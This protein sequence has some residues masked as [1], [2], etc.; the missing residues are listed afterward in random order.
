MTLTD[1]AITAFIQANL[2]LIETPAVP[3][4]RLHQ[5]MP[6]SGLHRLAAQDAAFGSPYW[7]YRWAGGLALA[8]HILDRPETV[9]GRHVLDL[10]A[11]SGLVAI[12]A[13]LAGA[14]A[15]HAV[16]VDRHAIIATGL[17]AAANGVRISV[18][19]A[20]LTRGAPPDAD[21]ILVGDL[22]YAPA[23]ARRVTRFLDRCVGAGIC[24]LVGDPARAHLARSRLEEVARYMVAETGPA[25]PAFV[26]T[27]RRTIPA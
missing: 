26:Y 8:R 12:A 14:A 10:G 13:A 4:I 24:V 20:D 6:A 1:A 27:Y 15:V 22:F 18:E 7:A 16:D 19:T 17:N 3:E 2:P 23:L 21:L 25:K 9:S 11:G 5:A